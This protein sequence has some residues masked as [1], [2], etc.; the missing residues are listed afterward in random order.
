MVD[1]LDREVERVMSPYLDHQCRLPT[2][3]AIGQRTAE[4]IIAEIV[5]T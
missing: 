4:V 1:G 2:I 3:P 5:S